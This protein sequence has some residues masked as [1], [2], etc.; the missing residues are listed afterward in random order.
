MNLKPLSLMVALSLTGTTASAAPW[1]TLDAR[2]G[3]MGGLSVVTSAI[4]VAAFN[5]PAMLAAGAADDDFGLVLA[6]G[7]TAADPND[8]QGA[9]SDFNTAYTAAD[10]LDPATILAAD[11]ALTNLG[12]KGYLADAGGGLASAF[13]WGQWSA[14][15]SVALTTSNDFGISAN[16]GIDPVTGLTDARLQ[17]ISVQSQDIGLSLARNFELGDSLDVALGVTPKLQTITIGEADQAMDPANPASVSGLNILSGTGNT[18]INAD[19]GV[20]ARYNKNIRFGVSMRNVIAQSYDSPLTTTSIE[21]QPQMRAGMAYTND[22]VTVGIDMDLVEN[23]AY[24]S[25]AKSKYTIIGSEFNA[26]DVT[27]LRLGYRTNSLDSNDVQASIGVG[28][29]DSLNIGAM[30]NPNNTQAGTSAYLSFNLKL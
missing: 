8:F 25:G 4:D 15:F 13:K 28:L 14:A 9:L 22:F 3:S 27:Q 12:G 20:V 10:P 1:I 19:L 2:S 18:A 6:L 5:N 7:A 21:I 17:G 26:W 29:F 11:T 23:T 16:T 24:V 30:T